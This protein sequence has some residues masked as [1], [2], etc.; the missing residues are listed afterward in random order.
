MGQNSGIEWTDATWNPWYGCRK[1]SPACAHCYAER[2]MTRFHKDFDTVTRAGLATVYAPQNWKEPKKIF[3]CSWSDFFIEDS[4][5][6]RVDAWQVIMSTPR[7]TYQ[8]L[9][10]RPEQIPQI[11]WP[12]LGMSKNVWLGV[13]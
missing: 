1:V 9:T 7:H 2:E 10:N 8:I 3:T 4:I 13:A 5:P 11:E 12:F 6:W